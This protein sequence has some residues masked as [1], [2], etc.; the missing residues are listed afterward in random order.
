MASSKEKRDG[1]IPVSVRFRAWWDG[2]DARDLMER[3]RR[4][5]MGDDLAFE[6]DETPDPDEG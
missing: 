1:Y 6:F 5:A 3:R 2:V 4:A